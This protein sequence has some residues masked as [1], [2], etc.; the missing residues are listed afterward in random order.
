MNWHS[1]ASHSYRAWLG[2]CVL[3]VLCSLA[4]ALSSAA[5]VTLAWDPNT[6]TDLAGYKLYY[7]TSSGSYPSSVDVGNLTSYTLSGLLEGR[8]YYFAAT[9]YDLNVNESGFSNEVS[10]AIADVTPPTVSITAPAAGATVLGTMTV[11]AS[12][13]D[14]VGIVGVQFKLDSVN[15]GAEVTAAPYTISWPTT[16]AT[17]AAHG[18]TAVARDAAGNTAASAAVSV[19][20]DNT[21]PVISLVSAF[22]IASSQATISWATNKA[23]D[24]QVDYGPTMAYGS[25]T[26]LN[27]SLLTAHAVT[28]TGLLATTTYHYRVKSR[29]AAGNLATSA[30]FTLTTLID[31]TPPTVSMTSPAAGSTVAGTIT[32]S[33]SAT[34]NVGVVG[35]QFKL[36][37]ANLGTEVTAAPYSTSWNTTL[38]AN[39]SHTLTAVARDAAG[40]TATSAAVSVTVSNS[41][42]DITP[43]SVPTNLS[44]SAVSSSQITLSWTASTDNVGVAGYQIYRGGSQIATTSL[45]R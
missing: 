40:N 11:S 4:P 9:A 18:L 20:V 36:D 1:L 33:A 22:N 34:D 25:S 35:V 27:S 6:E 13:T 38:A 24:S 37:G 28:L 8:T 32:V 7:G 19:T 41:V 3:T 44:A 31:T 12:A 30:D 29:D 39:G 45:T 26:P 5:Q 17:N 43:P 2:A 14:N 42:P 16:T 23:S 10:K 21:P 15:L